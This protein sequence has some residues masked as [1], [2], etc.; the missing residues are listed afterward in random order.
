MGCNFVE[1]GY[2][3]ISTVFVLIAIS[4]SHSFLILELLACRHLHLV[5]KPRL[6]RA[7][8]LEER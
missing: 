4:T 3:G 8:G 2:A 5:L 1:G 7:L 6:H